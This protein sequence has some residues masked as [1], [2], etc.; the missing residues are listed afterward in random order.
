MGKAKMSKRQRQDA[1]Y[2][3]AR[4]HLVVELLRCAADQKDY[5]R[6]SSGCNGIHEAKHDLGASQGVA[7]FAWR[8]LDSVG[9]FTLFPTEDYDAKLLE[10]AARVEE[11][12]FP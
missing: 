3:N 1:R 5:R 12:S 6:G 2:L 10:A 8:A 4:R 9:P 7:N 11:G